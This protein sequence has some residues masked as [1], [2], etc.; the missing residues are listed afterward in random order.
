MFCIQSNVLELVQRRT[1]FRNVLNYY[2]KHITQRYLMQLCVGFPDVYPWYLAFGVG[3]FP[4]VLE[5]SLLFLFI[6]FSDPH[7]QVI[8]N[9]RWINQ[10]FSDKRGRDLGCSLHFSEGSVNS[11]GFL[12]SFF[13]NAYHSK[14]KQ[15]MPTQFLREANTWTEKTVIKTGNNFTLG[16]FQKPSLNNHFMFS[17]TQV[18][19]LVD[20]HM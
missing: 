16:L 9:L 18:H 11:M 2:F 7:S 14:L 15:M 17:W 3:T 20:S 4:P 13:L 6:T 5:C 12:W 19:S 8:L 1:E 10:S